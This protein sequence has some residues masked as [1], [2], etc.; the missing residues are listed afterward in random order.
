MLCAMVVVPN[1]QN[2]SG[3]GPP[4]WPF[5]VQSSMLLVKGV[6]LCA[7]HEGFKV[8]E[9]AQFLKGKSLTCHKVEK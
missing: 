4:P 7:R 6:G 8:K 9:D 5:I 2:E 1:R 3:Y